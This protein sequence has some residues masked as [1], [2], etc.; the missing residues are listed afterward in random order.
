MNSKQPGTAPADQ[1]TPA[2]SRRRLGERLRQLRQDRALQLKDVAIW[3]DLVPST[4]SRIERGSA[5][6]RISYLKVMLDLYGVDDPAV[7]GDLAHLARVGQGK[8]WWTKLAGPLPNGMDAYLGAEAAASRIRVF[9]TQVIPGLLR[10]SDYAAAVI[11]A[12]QPG[13]RARHADEL[14]SVT[15][16]RQELL[17][18]QQASLHVVLDESC[19]LRTIGSA[20]VMAAQLGHLAATT[21]GPAVTVQVIR[22]TEPLAVLAPEF[23]LLSFPD[24]TDS[25]VA[26]TGGIGGQVTMITRG[27]DLTAL[28]DAFTTLA[29]AALSP[30]DSADLI[31]KL[32]NA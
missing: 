28:R 22:L 18:E 31:A 32:A 15:L 13:I 9:A 23:A 11:R 4:V 29:T 21:A 12:E 16:R 19:L 2:V 26:C 24:P 17:S 3:L 7:R 8:D 1:P 14:V 10:T 30:A 5:P 25:S 27:P 20:E 6:T